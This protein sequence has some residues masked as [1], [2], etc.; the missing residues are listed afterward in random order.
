MGHADLRETLCCPNARARN[1][2]MPI[3]VLDDFK[4]SVTSMVVT[5]HEIIAG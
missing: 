5:D 4:D 3:Q 2:Y 1:T